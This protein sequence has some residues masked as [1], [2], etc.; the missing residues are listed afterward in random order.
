MS[1]LEARLRA[2]RVAQSHIENIP[3]YCIFGDIILN[4]IVSRRP[5]S[6]SELDSVTSLGAIKCIQYGNDI[7]DIVLDSLC[8]GDCVV[9]PTVIVKHSK[10]NKL[11]KPKLSFSRRSTITKE[12]STEH[13]KRHKPV[14]GAYQYFEDDEDEVYIL[15]LERGRVYVGKS[16]NVTKRVGQ[17]HTGTGSAFTKEFPP[18]GVMLPRLGCVCGGG[19]AA[20]R[21]ET[22]RYM[23]LRGINNVRGWKYTRIRLDEDECN[24][25]ENNMRELFNLCRRCGHPGHFIGKCKAS[26]DR[27]GR[28]I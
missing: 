16:G 1:R 5:Q 4:A 28:P 22:L 12:E 17:H 11:K 20:E 23:F 18:T 7:I 3:Q 27:R 21:D 14:G 24:D 8:N 26:F 25:A 6:L 10:S 9:P 15:E 19:D 13:C 2:Y